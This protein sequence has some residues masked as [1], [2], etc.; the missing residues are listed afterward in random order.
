MEEGATSKGN[1]FS[2]QPPEG[3]QPCRHLDLSP[4][5]L[6]SD[7]DVQNCEILNVVVLYLFIWPQHA[8]CGILL[9]RPGIEPQ[10][11]AVKAWSPN[12]WT[13]REFPVCCF[14][15]FFKDLL[16]YFFDVDHLKSLY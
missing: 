4:G 1:G 13:T 9:P 7:Y 3:M 6:I 14:T 16:T 8:A 2:P 11:S 12:H 10:P 5:R 15:Y